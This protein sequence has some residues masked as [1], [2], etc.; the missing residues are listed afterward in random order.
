MA[1]WELVCQL[2]GSEYVCWKRG[3]RWPTVSG[4]LWISGAINSSKCK[5]PTLFI[6]GNE[7]I[8]WNNK[9]S[10]LLA[11]SISYATNHEPS[12]PIFLAASWQSRRICLSSL[13]KLVVICCIRW[14]LAQRNFDHAHR[15]NIMCWQHKV[16]R[17]TDIIVVHL[18]SLHPDQ[19]SA[20]AT[21]RDGQTTQP[22]FFTSTRET[23]PWLA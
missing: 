12:L 8:H 6:P 18:H 2:K 9:P 20:H 10:F 23:L 22:V 7:W 14:S 17:N 16:S 11:S 21:W 3:R 4:L 13:S 19:G 5:T 1:N 15:N